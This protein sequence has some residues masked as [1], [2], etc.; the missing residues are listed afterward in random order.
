MP[1]KTHE[2][3]STFVKCVVKQTSGTGTFHRATA[4]NAMHGIGVAILS[5]CPFV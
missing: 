3:P 2:D 4:C 5:V 1:T